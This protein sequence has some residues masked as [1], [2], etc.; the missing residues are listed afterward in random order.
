WKL[1]NKV[2]PVDE[3][4][5]V[6]RSDF[7]SIHAPLTAETEG[8][9]D[10]AFISKAKKGVS[11]FNFSR[12]AIA[13]PEA[14]KKALDS[15]QV[16]T[17]VTDFATPELL[18]YPGVISFPHLASGT[19]EAEDNCATMAAEQLREYLENGN[20]KN[21]VNFPTVDFG[22][23]EKPRVA[24]L[25]SNVPKILNSITTLV[26][27]SGQINIEKMANASKGDQAYTIFDLDSEL[28]AKSIANISANPNVFLV[29]AINYTPNGK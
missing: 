19:Y 25:H 10:E 6:R 8:K 18:N 29:R 3:D 7:I 12:A 24:V 1:N 20:I 28:D 27:L 23:P 16:K 5:L 22:I 11:L 21:S 9:Y 4:E 2:K 14:V 15:K 13:D 26:S 17:Y